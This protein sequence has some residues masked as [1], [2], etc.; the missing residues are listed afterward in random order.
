[1]IRKYLQKIKN[2]INKIFQEKDDNLKLIS[3]KQLCFSQKSIIPTR[4]SDIEFKVFSQWGEDG[5]IE[6]LVNIL[7]IENKFFIE[8]GVE[9][10]NE[11]NTRFLMMNRNWRGMIMDG[12]KQHID[13]VKERDYFWKFDLNP[14]NIFI[15]KEN[16]NGLI[17]DKLNKLKIDKNIGLLSVDIDGMDYWVLN[18]IDCIDPIIIICEYNSLFGN[19]VPLTVPYDES[20]IRGNYH[21]SNLYSGA[22]LKAFTDMLSKKGYSYI[23]SNLQNENAFFVKKEF[24]EQKL[25]HLLNNIPIFEASNVRESRDKNGNL[26]YLSGS[27]RIKEIQNLELFNLNTSKLVKIQELI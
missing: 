25:K 3:G 13:Y 7:D 17:S 18:E 1:M 26:N 4:L 5:I 2:K 8:F 10:Y 6:Y 19:E 11:S 15:T 27:D 20:F 24:A 9:N 23:G 21:Y 12:S 22:N 16:I 14:I